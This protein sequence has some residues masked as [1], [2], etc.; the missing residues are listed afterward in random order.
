M[1][2]PWKFIVKECVYVTYVDEEVK[3]GT[4]GE[5]QLLTFLVVS[6][7]LVLVL[8]LDEQIS[9]KQQT[10]ADSIVSGLGCTLP[11]SLSDV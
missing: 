6:F 5:K 1:P 2:Y 4:R 11:C 8:E 7:W 3:G 9:S 10:T